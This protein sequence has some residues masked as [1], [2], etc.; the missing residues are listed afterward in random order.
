M[1]VSKQ[2]FLNNITVLDYSIITPS[3][4]LVGGSFQ[5]SAIVS[6]N[7]S[8]NTTQLTKD[9]KSIIRDSEVGYHNKIILIDNFSNMQEYSSS[10]SEQINIKTENTQLC[11]SENVI[12]PFLVPFTNTLEETF[13]RELSFFVSFKLSQL[14]SD[15]D[16]SADVII[17]KDMIIQ[18]TLRDIIRINFIHEE[19]NNVHGHYSFLAFESPKFM[20]QEKYNDLVSNICIKNKPN[21]FINKN[22]IIDENDES[23]TTCF[24]TSS[25]LFEITYLKNSYTLIVLQQ[26]TSI[27]NILNWFCK[28][29]YFD[30]KDLGI[31]KVYL[32]EGLTSGAMKPL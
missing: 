11:V 29:F 26:E 15:C 17:S 12:S 14:Y 9:I 10:S 8:A 2:L 20:L 16:I 30:L 3:G 6:G 1:S 22:S 7:F 23:L 31:T 4:H 19:K 5:I 25:G 32:S 13:E 18:K 28:T 24:S 21:V 27:E